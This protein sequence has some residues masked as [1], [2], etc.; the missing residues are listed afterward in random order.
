MT[1][2]KIDL[3][4]GLVE[5][6]GD[7]ALVKEV[8]DDYK[9]VLTQLLVRPPVSLGTPATLVQ[10]NEPAAK[11]KKGRAAEKRPASSSKSKESHGIVKDLDLR[12]EGKVSFRDF[13]DEKAPA[14]D[15]QM[16]LVAVYYL[17][18]VLQ[19]KGI[20]PDHVHTCYKAIQRRVP[21]ALTQ[22][23][24]NTASRYGWLDTSDTTDVKITTA[25]ENFVEHDMPTK[26][27]TVAT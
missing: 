4:N 11:Q 25:G 7:D 19:L 21:T 20:T 23:L 13:A 17:G 15:A 8:Y 9:D 27:V 3:K 2:L 26:K 22:G 6:E 16:N 12:P 10:G 5:V 14:S 24:R 1:K 18:N